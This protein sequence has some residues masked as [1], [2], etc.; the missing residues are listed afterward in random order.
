MIKQMKQKIEP[1]S[2]SY[3]IP[4]ATPK[5]PRTRNASCMLPYIINSYHRVSPVLE[6]PPRTVA[7]PLSLPQPHIMNHE[8]EGKKQSKGVTNERNN[9]ALGPHDRLNIN[10]TNAV[11]LSNPR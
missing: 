2:P 11:W 9:R 7:T 6:M 10:G 1:P 4:A 8:P 3:A 5:P